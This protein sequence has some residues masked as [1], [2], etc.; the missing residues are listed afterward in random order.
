MRNAERKKEVG[1]QRAEI[2]GQRADDRD[3]MAEVRGR[4][5]EDRR[6]KVR[7]WEDGKVRSNRDGC[8]RAEF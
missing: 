5:S 2:R 3:Q 8:Q 7:G 1:G 4:R 6:K